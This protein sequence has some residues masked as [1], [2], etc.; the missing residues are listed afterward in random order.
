MKNNK[1]IPNLIV[2]GF[3]KSGTSSLFD[4]LC[5]H[6]DIYNPKIKE[7][8]MYAFDDRYLNRFSTDDSFNF[9]RFYANTENYKYI[10]DA[11]TIYLRSDKALKRIKEDT[12]NA[13]II[14][15]ARDPIER[16]FSHYN[17]L[18]MSGNKQYKF[19]KEIKVEHSNNFSPLNHIKGNYKNYIQ[20]SLYGEQLKRCFEIFEHK[21]IYITSLERLKNNFE[22]VLNEIFKHLEIEPIK[23]KGQPKNQ[24]PK[25]ARIQKVVPSKL[26]KIEVIL[27][28]RVLSNSFLLKKNLKP[29]KFNENDEKFVFDFIKNDLITLQEMNLVFPEWKTVNKY[30]L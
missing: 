6:P 7:P 23:V 18:K 19:Q 8:H 13:K 15:I 30:L 25:T 5:Q 24:T 28:T 2:P 3:P 1:Q 16:V 9:K 21:N 27:N 10:P 22:E 29:T 4:Y 20:F 17:W 26:K 14:I 12:D 11:S